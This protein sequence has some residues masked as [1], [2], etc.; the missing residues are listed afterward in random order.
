[1]GALLTGVIIGIVISIPIGPI[2]VT[3]ISKGFKQGFKEAFAVG[4]GASTMD[5][6]YCGATM[7]GLSAVV[8]K[9]E[10]NFVF[11][12]IGFF[13][14]AYLGIRDI[15]TKSDNFRYDKAI[16]KNNGSFHSSYLV[17]VIMY[18]S[19]PTLVA[20]W[21][22]LSGIIQATDGF[23]NGIGD[24]ILFAVG[25]GFGTTLWYYSLLRAIFLKRSSFKAETLTVLTRISGFI[26]LSFSAY[27]GYEMLVR[28]TSHGIK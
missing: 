11:Q 19:N 10:M 1:M 16:N 24:G 14:L 8:H 5:F 25:V 23:I 3:I 13:L 21:I 26:M 27:I 18:I 12:V 7:L 20:F 2:N 6:F 17:G 4:L 28:F 9:L 22:T 15:V